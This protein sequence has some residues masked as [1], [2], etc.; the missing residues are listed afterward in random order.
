MTVKGRDLTP[1]RF[2]TL[3]V[4]LML[5]IVVGVCVLPHSRHLRFASLQE[6]TV[7]KLGWLYERIHDDPTPI[8]I[9]FIGSSHTVFGVDS[10]EVERRARLLIGQDVHVVNFA[11]QHLGRDVPWLLAREAIEAR[12]VK[13]LV[14]EVT[15]D[16]SRALHP[17]FASLADPSDLID[18]PLL[19]NPS[20]FSELAEL[21]SRQISLFLRTMLPGAFDAAPGFNPIQY[22]GAH[23]DD[24]WAQEGSIVA[25]IHPVVPRITSPSATKM[26][27]ERVHWA[28][29]T[30]NKLSLPSSLSWL[31]WRANLQYIDR[32]VALARRHGVALRVLYLPSY[33]SA[34]HPTQVAVYEK[35]GLMWYPPPE[36]LADRLL[37]ND[38][39]HLNYYGS[40]VLA[41]WLAKCIAKEHIPG[42]QLAWHSFQ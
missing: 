39:N 29:L 34:T 42:A 7:V 2:I 31:E 15:E 35:L 11:V 28:R 33:H 10:A 22:R 24:T 26:E 17:A 38:V 41:S 12:N 9:I 16:E 13:L 20:Y 6:P 4:M 18:A 1:K 8:D 23:W 30:S 19:I 21:P 14:V 37:W 25:P 5:A 36:L 32:I 40:L 27:N 3:T